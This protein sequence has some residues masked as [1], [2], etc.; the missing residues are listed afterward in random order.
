MRRQKTQIFHGEFEEQGWPPLRS[1]NTLA[2]GDLW[3]LPQSK[4]LAAFL[5]HSRRM[6]FSATVAYGLSLSKG[7]LV[8][9]TERQYRP[10]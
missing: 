5:A 3:I 9:L 4:T 1:I 10:E 7:G 6:S 8:R 2:R